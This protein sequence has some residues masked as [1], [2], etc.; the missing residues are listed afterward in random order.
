MTET[1]P[2]GATMEKLSGYMTVALT[3]A[4]RLVEVQAHRRRT[5]LEQAR[6]HSE[7]QAR[8]VQAQQRAEIATTRLQLRDVGGSEWWNKASAEEVAV[9]YATARSYGQ[10][11]PELAGTA[12]YMAE[13][14]EKRYGVD[15]EQ[16]V[17]DAERGV[18]VSREMGAFDHPA[19]TSTAQEAGRAAAE[20]AAAVGLLAEAN[21]V[22][23]AVHADGK[24]DVHEAAH[25][26][27]FV[28]S[29]WD[30]AG[31]RETLAARLEAA[32]VP[33][34]AVQARTVSD[35]LQGKPAAAA[36]AAT[37]TARTAPKVRN[38]PVKGAQRTVGR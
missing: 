35:A 10:L 15:A 21:V 36:P 22:D 2:V 30:E 7:E 24:V 13:Q 32:A 18:G 16:L 26:V 4:A 8:A 20:R 5:Q 25:D 14:I 19:A 31:R 34:D 9:S 17:R 29:G 6:R 28:E 37:Q 1:D 23:A 3:V 27:P 33:A 38:T 11:D 12:R